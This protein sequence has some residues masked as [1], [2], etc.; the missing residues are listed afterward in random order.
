MRPYFHPRLVNQP[1]GDPALFIQFLHERR[2][3]LFDLG[4]ISTLSAKDILK[5][6]HVFI[7]H[8]HIDHFIGFDYLLRVMLGREK[9]L[10]I[11]GPAGILKN[12]EG[13]L[14]GY[15]WN[16]VENYENNFCIKVSEVGYE[17]IITKEYYC[18]D[19][20]AQTNETRVSK[21]DNLIFQSP[22][23]LVYTMA[24]DHQIPS[25]AFRMEEKFHVNI[26]KEGLARLGLCVGP[27]IKGLKEAIHAGKGWDELFQVVYMQQ[28]G[29][30]LCREF[31]L[32]EL[33]KE[34]TQIVPGQKVVYVADMR[35][36]SDNIE[37]AVQL[38]R[39]ADILF[40]E[41]SFL[42]SEKELAYEKYHLTARQAGLIARDAGVKELRIF[43][44]SPRYT[45]MSELLFQEAHEAFQG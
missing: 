44:F 37:K 26:V 42:H 18:R 3:F 11:A 16:L 41:S 10:C 35:Y 33:A 31:P 30:R 24:L 9:K 6:T 25:L 5:L 27:W 39:D 15:S 21:F 14:A 38:A 40:I 45:G 19:S 7:S 43:H 1:Q 36:T 29:K 17:D 12:V 28:D 32:G 20:F 22:L 23:F 4:D 2:A 8:T 13:K 34:A